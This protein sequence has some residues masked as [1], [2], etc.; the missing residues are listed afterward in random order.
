MQD[1]EQIPLLMA[2]T[3]VWPVLIWS[4]MG[5]RE[6]SYHTEQVVFST[7]GQIR[8]QLPAAWLAGYIVALL[9]AGGVMMRLAMEGYWYYLPGIIVGAAF[10]ASLALV[11][12]VASRGSKVFEV[13]Y[14]AFFWYFG[15]VNGVP[16]LDFVG[17]SEQAG[18]AVLYHLAAAFVFFAAAALLRRRQAF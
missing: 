2:L 18:G 11:L 6:V 16:Y 15:L 13:I 7:P 1:F 14:T 4:K 8:R 10:V 9:S 3:W 12:G 17:F 5:C